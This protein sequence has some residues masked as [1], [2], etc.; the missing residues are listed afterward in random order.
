MQNKI[1]KLKLTTA[2]II[3]VILAGYF[4]FSKS[5]YNQPNPVKASENKAVEVLVVT[6]TKQKLQLFQDLP[7]RVSAYKIS[8]VRPQ[9]EGVIR[10]INFTEGSFIK[11]GQQLYQIDPI[12]Y[13]AAA[14]S[15]KVNLSAIKAKRDRYKKL[16][17]ENAVSKQEFDDL[18]ALLAQAEAD[19][20]KAKTN[21]NYT[22]V[23]A[24]ISGFVGK[25]NLT[26]GALVSANQSEVLTTITQ[27]EPIYVDM[28]QPAK[29]MLKMGDQNGIRVSVATDEINYD[30]YGEL[31]F[32]E[33]FADEGTESVRLRAVFS[34][35][36]KK[37]IP[38]MF[39]TAKLHLKEI[40][41]IL[42]PQ[43]AASRSPEGNLTVWIVDKENVVNSRPI[44]AE[45]VFEDSWIVKEGLEEGEIVVYEGY[46]KIANGA[47]VNPVLLDKYLSNEENA[48]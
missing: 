5:K 2:I 42:V 48:K 34:N 47:K 36:D 6:A 33:V 14:A 32:S 39:V 22:K 3:L 23:L 45:K 7:A 27:L 21:F 25:T 15:A 30:I 43:R 11:K 28:V 37:L 1:K 31:K 29:D 35:T 44:K 8:E 46:Q 38:G 9:I 20:K 13:K 24:P 40:E 16:L 10:K 17:K 41:A 4:L 26:E 18:E 19:A 12:I